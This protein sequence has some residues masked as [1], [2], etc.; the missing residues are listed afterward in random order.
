MSELRLAFWNVSN[1]FE[2]GVV[3]RGPKTP[4]E[5]V[6]KLDRTAEVIGRLFSGDGP[7][8]LGL[9]EVNTERLLDELRS[10]LTDPFLKVWVPPARPEH[11]GLALL[12]RG[13]L[14]ADL[15]LLAEQR[16][17]VLARPRCAV[18][19]CQIRGCPEPIL[20]AL[21]HWKSRMQQ[22]VGDDRSDRM[23]TARWLGD[24][25]A[26]STRE[27]CAL[28]MG[29]FNAEPFEPPFLDASL[30]SV[31]FFSTALWSQASPAHLY[32]TAWRSLPEPVLWEAAQQSGYRDPRP[33]T[34]HDSSPP[35]LFDQLLV[36]GRAL[37]SGPL[38]LREASVGYHFD[39][40]NSIWTR[41]GRL[42]PARWTEASPGNWTGASDHFPLTAVFTV[43]QEAHS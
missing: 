6:A 41:S 24:Y 33:K 2:P 32:N 23:E 29:D 35:V 37:K 36:S 9:V 1:L 22:P 31:R 14:V 7:D 8:V 12:G 16:P 38:Q 4:A 43:T 11:T 28:A 17:S 13:T 10:R 19:R 39:S 15:S 25:L 3:D 27:T 30:R 34:S 5:L 18:V 42:T 40:V 26:T 20:V 21:N